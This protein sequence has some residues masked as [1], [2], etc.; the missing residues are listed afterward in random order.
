MVVS[1]RWSTIGVDADDPALA[2]VDLA[3]EAVGRL[4]DLALRV[5][6]DDRGDHAAPP[7]DLVDVRPDLALD[8]VGERL[9]EPRARRAGRPSR[10]RP[11]SSA[12]T[13]CWRSASS[14]ASAVGTASAS[15]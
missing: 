1:S 6:L 15:S 9:D 8:L 11:V 2:L 14:A 7:V 10:S 13:C 12:M 5:A 3:L 4:G